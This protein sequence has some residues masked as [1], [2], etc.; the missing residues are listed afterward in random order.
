MNLKTV[1]TSSMDENI[2]LISSQKGAII[3]DPGEMNNEIKDFISENADKEFAILLTHNHFDH[4]MGANEARNLS[5]GKIF[6]CEADAEGLHDSSMNL[7]ERFCVV[8]EDFEADVFLNDGEEFAVGDISV[9]VIHTPGHS[10]GSVC[11]IIGD[12]MF[13]GDTLFRL[14][15]GRTDFAGSDR[16][17]QISSL[18]RLYSIDGEY[19]IY[20]GHG[21]ATRL[22]FEKQ[23][24]PYMKEIL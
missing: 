12:R 8:C 9:K 10:E 16:N 18:R 2:Y 13:S 17:K 6:I 1:T 22:S 19:E 21:A 14:S 11:Y 3:I 24:N 20:P 5:K 23:Y 15:V 7:S 4:I